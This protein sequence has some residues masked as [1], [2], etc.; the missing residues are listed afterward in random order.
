MAAELIDE[1]LEIGLG[2]AARPLPRPARGRVRPLL[3]GG[4][5]LR[6]TSSASPR[7]CSSSPASAMQSQSLMEWVLRI[8]ANLLRPDEL[9]P[10]EA[11]YRAVAEHRQRSSPSASPRARGARLALARQAR[12]GVEGDARRRGSWPRPGPTSSAGRALRRRTSTSP[13]SSGR[14]VPAGDAVVVAAAGGREPQGVGDVGVEARWRSSSTS[15]PPPSSATTAADAS[16]P[17]GQAGE[18]DLLAVERARSSS[19]APRR[20]RRTTAAAAAPPARRAARRTPAAA[21]LRARRGRRCGRRG[22]RAAARRRPAATGRRPGRRRASTAA[23][24]S[25]LSA[26][27][28]HAAQPAEVRDAARPPRRARAG[29][30]ASRPGARCHSAQASG[31]QPSRHPCASSAPAHGAQPVV[32]AALHGALRDA[33][34]VGHLGVGPAA[35]VDLD[36]HAPVVVV[37]LG[38]RRL[39]LPRGEH[40]VDARRRR[41]RRSAGAVAV[42]RRAADGTRRARARSITTLRRMANSQV[43]CEDASRVVGRRRPPRPHER[44]LHGVLGQPGVA[45]RPAGEA[46]ELGAVRVV[47]GAERGVGQRRAP[48]ARAQPS[49]VSV[50][51][52]S[53]WISQW[54]A[55]VARLVGRGA[56]LGRRR[57]RRPRRGRRRRRRRWRCGAAARRSAGRSPRPAPTVRSVSEKS[58]ATIVP[59]RRPRRRR[60]RRCRRRRRPSGPPVRRRC[61][62]DPVAVGSSSTRRRPARRGAPRRQRRGRSGRGD[63]RAWVMAGD[64]DAPAPMVHAMRRDA[65]GC[66]ALHG[67]EVDDRS[68]AGVA[69]RRHAGARRGDREVLGLV[70]ASS[71]ADHRLKTAAA[72]QR[73]SDRMRRARPRSRRRRRPRHRAAWLPM[74]TPTAMPMADARVSR[75]SRSA[76]HGVGG[77]RHGEH[78]AG[79][80]EGDE[81]ERRRSPRTRTAGRRAAEVI[82]P[83]QAALRRSAW[84]SRVPRAMAAVP[85]SVPIGTARRAGRGCRRRARC[86]SA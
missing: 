61:R 53:A 62:S 23:T 74:S 75:L 82:A 12:L 47:G 28:R 46:V 84:W 21:A 22:R 83:H 24:A 45:E 20:R 36:Q 37:E 9:G 5:R 55:Y 66:S 40:P 68:V 52:M 54:N 16:T 60:R 10:A 65:G 73:A 33:E 41:R 29:P 2:H 50:A 15:E 81:G 39:H 19:P 78:A 85:S 3:P 77:D 70:R 30:P 4:P 79:D 42:A 1:A 27:A 69:A 11:A 44:L 63:G 57:R 35:P 56:G 51:V 71:T 17:V 86:R 31:A 59:A 32:H 49:T 14:N 6:R 8:M 76:D 18:R 80:G 34:L 43:R 38:E 7:S 13:S 67:D 72:R 58:S 26:S 64:T 48:D 25:R